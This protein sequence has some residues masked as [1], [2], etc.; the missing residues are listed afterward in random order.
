[1]RPGTATSDAWLHEPAVPGPAPS[2]TYETEYLM[3]TQ[4]ELPLQILPALLM[5]GWAL[6][7]HRLY[8]RLHQG[9]RDP[10]TGLLTREGWSRRAKRTLNRHPRSAVILLDLD[11]FKP[12]ND[13]FGHAAGDAVLAATGQRL[14]AWCEGIGTAGRLGGDE[15]VLA[16]EDDGRLEDRLAGLA[17]LLRQP[18]THDGHTL[19]V[20]ASLGAARRR[21]LPAPN[22]S[23][24]LA[25]A[26]AAMYRIKGRTRRGRRLLVAVG[27]RLHL[28]L[29]A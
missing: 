3:M 19:R 26:D 7:A 18:V 4:L 12:V 25:A 29:A 6:H 9:R 10:L 22:L 21:D 23:D 27:K 1:M 14:N 20:G 16:L 24:A 28:R 5:L 17:D 13:K 15:F 8:R 2:R 11:G